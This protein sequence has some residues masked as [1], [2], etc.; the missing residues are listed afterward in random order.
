MAISLFFIICVFSFVFLFKKDK[1]QYQK[2]QE[3]AQKTEPQEKEKLPENIIWEKPSVSPSTPQPQKLK[4]PPSIIDRRG[5]I[6][7]NT[8]IEQDEYGREVIEDEI[9]ITVRLGT[10]GSELETLEKTY[11]LVLKYYDPSLGVAHFQI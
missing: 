7:P 9:V 6:Q 11:P 10:E 4:E 3:I 5:L 8:K 1:V 2:T